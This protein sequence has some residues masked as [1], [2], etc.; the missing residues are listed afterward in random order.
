[1]GIFSDFANSAAGDL[2]IGA[3]EGLNQAAQNT[4]SK[5]FLSGTSIL[6]QNPALKEDYIRRY[7][8]PIFEGQEPTTLTPPPNSNDSSV[9]DGGSIY[10][11]PDIPE[12]DIN[13]IGGSN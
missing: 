5:T 7:G 4:V 1:M 13:N 11:D 3:F 6:D 10:V 2:T 12:F 8:E 9:G